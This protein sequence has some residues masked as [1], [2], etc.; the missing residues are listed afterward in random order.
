MTT[1]E[2]IV[3]P[4]EVMAYLDGELPPERAASVHAHLV[5]CRTCQSLADDLREVSDDLR[6]WQ[7]DAAPDSVRAPAA[8]GGRATRVH[9]LFASWPAAARPAAAAAAVVLALGAVMWVAEFGA[10]R[11]SVSAPLDAPAPDTRSISFGGSPNRVSASADTGTNAELEAIRRQLAVVE[12]PP[13]V[14]STRPTIG[15]RGRVASQATPVDAPGPKIVRTVNLTMV[16]KDFAAVRPA[17]DRVLHDVG[18]FVGTIQVSGEGRSGSLG[19]TMRV[20]AT[21]LD[22][23]VTALRGLGRVLDE[24]QSGDDVSEQVRDLEARLINSRN[25]EKRLTDVLRNR[26]GDVS[27][28]LQVE[29]EIARVREEIERMDAERTTLE[30]RV[31]YA[32]ITLRVDRERQATLDMGPLPV[33]AK[34]RNA[35]VDGLRDAFESAL[36]VVLWTLRSAPTLLLWVALLWW[37]VRVALRRGRAWTTS[38][39]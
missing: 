4:E 38:A 10:G 14:A 27:D 6:V 33:S 37:P 19:A 26:T 17:I 24:T 7:V 13:Q 18:G 39:G 5:D 34:F 20:P 36:A 12:P 22:A 9:R 30:G 29:R 35:V 25:T 16:T 3:A 21:R 11:N 32:T 31:S 2:H 28:V 23:A 15:S 8:P 1:A